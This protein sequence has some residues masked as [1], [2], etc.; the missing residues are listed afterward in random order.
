MELLHILTVVV[1]TLVL[2]L[3]ELYTKGK[4]VTFIV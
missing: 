4:K 3:I 1:V 2:K